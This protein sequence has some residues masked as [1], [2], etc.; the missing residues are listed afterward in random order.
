[1]KSSVL[2]ILIVVLLSPCALE[3]QQ[4]LPQPLEALFVKGVQAQRAGRLE[5]AENAFSEVLRQGGKVAFVYNNLGGVYQQQGDHTKALGQLREAVRL[6]PD[7][8][9][10]RFLMGASL[11]ALGKV[12][13]AI[14]ELERAVK[15]DPSQPLG[16]LQLVKAYELSGNPLAVAD[17]YRR[18]RESHPQDPEYAYQ[19]GRAYMKLSEWAFGKLKEVNPRSALLYLTLARNY[20]LQGRDELAERTLKQAIVLDP[21]LP[22]LHLALAEIYQAQGKVGEARAEVERELAIMPG[23]LAALALRERLSSTAR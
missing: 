16:R 14:R 1:M 8:A 22:E 10:P 19:L 3:A 23:S 17:Q 15:L 5:E 18:L 6:Q 7:Y 13:D 21:N 11:L 2:Q 4:A 9:A 12:P 20:R